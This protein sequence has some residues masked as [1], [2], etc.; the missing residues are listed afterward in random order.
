MIEPFS[1]FRVEDNGQRVWQTATLTLYDAIVRVKQ[2]AA[3]CSGEYFI[4]SQQSNVEVSVT[5]NPAANGSSPQ[6]IVRS[7]SAAR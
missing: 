5:V 2:I 4:R 6:F 3:P 1:V 7:K